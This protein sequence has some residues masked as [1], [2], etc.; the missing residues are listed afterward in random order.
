M[1]RYSLFVLTVPLNNNKPNRATLGIGIIR[2]DVRT[3]GEDRAQYGQEGGWV[4]FTVFCE[5]PLWMTPSE[6]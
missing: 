1:T 6:K 3:E 5:R 4:D 2:D